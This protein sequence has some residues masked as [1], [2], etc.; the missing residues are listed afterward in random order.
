M[1]SVKAKAAKQ[2]GGTRSETLRSTLEDEIISGH[3]APGQRLDEARLAERFKVS[4]TPVREALRHLASSGL[5]EMRMRQG[6]VVR[7]MTIAE[8]IDSFQVMAELEGLCARLAARRISLPQRCALERAHRT[9]VE[10]AGQRDPDGFYRANLAFHETIYAAC[11]NKVLEDYTYSLRR[12]VG[13]YRRY[14]TYSPGRMAASNDE[15]EA[16]MR[17]VFAGREKEADDLMREHVGLLGEEIADL[18]SAMRESD[19]E[20]RTAG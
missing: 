14:V 6:A 7:K 15:H 4:R 20:L 10:T 9:C 1:T 11:Q 17:A 19:G 2:P 12:A 3:L 13:P 18:V 8:L 5:V 16:V